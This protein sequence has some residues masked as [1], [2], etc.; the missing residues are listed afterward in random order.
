MGLCIAICCADNISAA[1]VAEVEL[2]PF[3]REAFGLSFSL[4]GFSIHGTFSKQYVKDPKGGTHSL[5]ELVQNLTLRK[6]LEFKKTHPGTFKDLTMGQEMYITR[7]LSRSMAA[8]VLGAPPVFTAFNS[9]AIGGNAAPIPA[10][11]LNTWVGA[12]QFVGN[13]KSTMPGELTKLE[14]DFATAIY[15]DLQ[16]YPFAVH[17]S[18]IFDTLAR[19]KE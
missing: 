1:S 9:R 14:T 13:P 11:F 8:H 16:T 5:K 6:V 7:E 19:T 3:F 12:Q 17:L 18:T 15:R 10:G 2:D 4:D